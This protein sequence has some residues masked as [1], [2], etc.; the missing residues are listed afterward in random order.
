MVR[1]LLGLDRLSFLE[2]QRPGMLLGRKLKRRILR[3]IF[4]EFLGSPQPES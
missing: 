4:G 1:P 3:F 2:E